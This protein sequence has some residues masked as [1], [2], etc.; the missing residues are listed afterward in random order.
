MRVMRDNHGPQ[1]LS[2][3]HRVQG[4]VPRRLV[5]LLRLR[6]I[7]GICAALIISAGCNNELTSQPP[8]NEPSASRTDITNES[9]VRRTL[10]FSEARR[11]G[12]LI[13]RFEYGGSRNVLGAA[14][15]CV[16]SSCNRPCP[17]TLPIPPASFDLDDVGRYWINDWAKGRVAVFGPRGRFR[18]AVKAPGNNYRNMDIQFHSDEMLVLRHV[19]DGGLGL[20]GVMGRRVTHVRSV[21]VNDERYSGSTRFWTTG[22]RVFVFL[23]GRVDS[24]ACCEGFAE[25]GF[26]SQP[27]SYAVEPVP[28]LP[29]FDGWLIERRDPDETGRKII[30]VADASPHAWTR[31]IRFRLVQE[32]DGQQRDVQ[33][34]VSWEIEI[35]PDGSVHILLFAG[36]FGPDRHRAD[37]YW[38]LSIAAD[39]QVSKAIALRA[40]NPRDD[41]QPN[42]TYQYRRLTLDENGLP[43]VM[44]AGPK[45]ARIER[46][47]P[48]IWN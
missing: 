38:Y 34:G 22:D 41:N 18:F 6:V 23:H 43:L 21:K 33:G 26:P 12:D 32:R 2:V 30:Y 27:Y 19:S 45:A 10:D 29:F 4:G 11:A 5:G 9:V 37:G 8:L 42:P 47:P 48:A 31:E 16:G 35:A 3:S 7:A 14:A 24:P 20:F 1:E 36:T 13:N 15:T 46:L 44:W 17:C 40:P 28:G 39:G 25:L